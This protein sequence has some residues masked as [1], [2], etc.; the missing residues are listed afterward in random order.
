M[1]LL[2]T[3][4]VSCRLHVVSDVPVS[5]ACIVPYQEARAGFF[6]PTASTAP[7]CSRAKPRRARHHSSVAMAASIS[8]ARFVVATLVATPMA[9]A[10]LA[11]LGGVIVPAAHFVFY[12]RA[13]AVV[14][15][16]KRVNVN[17]PLAVVSAYLRT[18]ANLPTYEPKV[19]A[20]LL[21]GPVD[22]GGGASVETAPL[23][24]TATRV[25]D[26][27]RSA[28][29]PPPAPPIK[30]TLFGFWV[31]LPWRAT[32]TMTP[33]RNGGFHSALAPLSS[34]YSGAVAVLLRITGGFV[35]GPRRDGAPGTRIVHYE[36]YDWPAAYPLLLWG[37]RMVRR[38]HEE[39][40]EV[41]MGV[42]RRELEVAA[43]ESDAAAVVQG[44]RE[45]LVAAPQPLPT[46]GGRMGSALRYVTGAPL[47]F[48][49]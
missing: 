46:T 24:T 44:A 20:S 13:R 23:S 35:L 15:G 8:L 2:N 1:F 10:W 21:I 27:L 5:N 7:L 39:G 16:I 45:A 42:L 47:H 3:F 18:L 25:G 43:A 29:P 26:F 17:A 6:P 49:K 41:E 22:D 11:L 32:F 12:P 38:W 40:M 34:N 30:Y 4:Y 36:R 14:F 31:G 9:L 48:A 19:V 37:G 33:T 28:Q